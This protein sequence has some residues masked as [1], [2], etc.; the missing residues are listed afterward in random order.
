[1]TLATWRR[2]GWAWFA[3][4]S[5]LALG[6]VLAWGRPPDAID[7]Q[8]ALAWRQPW[9]AWSA[10]FVHYSGLHLLGNAA[11][12]SLVTAFGLAARAPLR[13]AMAWAVAWPLT[14]FG[15]LTQPALAHYGGLSGV[16]HAGVA[17]VCAHLIW[18]GQWFIGGS[19]FAGLIVKV[20]SEAPWGPPLRHWP[21]WD[22]TLAPLVHASGVVA[23]L[24]CVLLAEATHALRARHGLLRMQN[25]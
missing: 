7:W 5:T 19:V 2:P 4:A 24:I 22:I 15:L 11:G 6:T 14:Q 8:P 9:R 1:M 23:G 10:V 3:V 18:R 13:L 12:L 20:L 25:P 16:V 21:G 17:I